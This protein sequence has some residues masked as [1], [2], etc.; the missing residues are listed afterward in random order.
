MKT[1]A[2][3]VL[4]I[5]LFIAGRLLF[6]PSA[7]PSRVAYAPVLGAFLVLQGVQF[8][9]LRGGRNSPRISW[10]FLSFPHLSLSTVIY[11]IPSVIFGETGLRR[12]CV[13]AEPCLQ[14][15]EIVLVSAT[16]GAR[17][18]RLAPSV[19]VGGTQGPRAKNPAFPR[20]S[21]SISSVSP[22]HRPFRPSW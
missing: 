8:C 20:P 13:L 5:M 1:V 4:L 10:S 18:V 12:A 11:G 15:R 9:L 19:P 2:V 16:P 21:I 7:M 17:G 14:M 6:K 22:S 3:A